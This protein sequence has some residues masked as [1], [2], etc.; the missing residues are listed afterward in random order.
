M[1]RIALGIEYFGTNYSGWQKQKSTPKTVQENLEKALSSI[2]NH[3]VEVVCSGRTDAGVHALSQIIHFDSDSKRFKKAWIQGTNSILPNDIS[4]L[5]AKKVS[6]NFHA[7]FSAINRTY[8]YIIVNRTQDSIIRSKKVMLV[9]EKINLE[10]MKSAAS[11][12]IGE[13]DFTSFRASGCQ[14]KTAMRNIKKI[15]ISKNKN[16]FTIEI[17][18]NA[19]LF[20]MVRIIVGTLIKFATEEIDPAVMKKILMNKDRRLAG[21]TAIADGLYFIG[22]QYP[23]QFKL[24]KLPLKQQIIPYA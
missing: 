21:K 8:K 13:N 11:Y 1:A 23:H 15:D 16:T 22:A 10:I 9:K 24:I 20:N 12:L 4:V 5:W 19:F 14:S 6:E 18:G 7:R 3:K 2:A 17:S